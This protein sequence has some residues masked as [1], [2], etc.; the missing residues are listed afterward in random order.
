[1]S[2][3]LGLLGG[4]ALMALLIW[5]IRGAVDGVLGLRS[6]GETRPKTAGF[7]LVKFFTRHAIVALAA[8]VLMVRLHADPVGII[9][10][11]SSVVVAV[12]IEAVRG[13]RWRRF[14]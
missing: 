6:D 4:A 9:V 5:A 7:M 12:T 14:L 11:V 13:F 8:Y 1:V 2:L 10:G 3:V